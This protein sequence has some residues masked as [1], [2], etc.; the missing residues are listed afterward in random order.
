MKTAFLIL[1][2]DYPSKIFEK[3]LQKL[4]L[5]RDSIIYIHHDS[6]QN[7]FDDSLIKKYNLVM[8]EKCYRTYW[9]HIN[10]VKATWEGFEFLMNNYSPDWIITITPTCYPIKSIAK[11]EDFLENTKFDG[12]MIYRK[13]TS[14]PQWELDKWIYRDMYHK[15][16]TIPIINRP[17]FIKRNPKNVPFNNEFAI[18]HSSNY[19]MLNNKVVKQ[20]L[21]QKE[22]YD[23]IVKFYD[24]MGGTAQFPCPQ[25][26]VLQ[27][28]IMNTCKDVNINNNYYRYIKWEPHKWSPIYLTENNLEEITKTDALFARKFKDGISDI[29]I[30]EI[31]KI[32]ETNK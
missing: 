23:K 14:T 15:K 22:I 13:V 1:S 2:C 27:S 16:N 24:Q 31:D 6:Y 29:I 17:I 20:M 9:S 3:L 28:I 32:I 12:F 25:E 21:E 30:E 19:F 7:K 18:W 8:A 26:I 10:N 11:I 5:F 4:S